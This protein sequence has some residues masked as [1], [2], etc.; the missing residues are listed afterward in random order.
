MEAKSQSIVELVFDERLK[1]FLKKAKLNL[2]MLLIDLQNADLF[3]AMDIQNEIRKYFIKHG[4]EL[5]YVNPKFRLSTHAPSQPVLFA[6]FIHLIADMDLCDEINHAMLQ[7]NENSITVGCKNITFT[8]NNIFVN[9][10]CSHSVKLHNVYVITNTMTNMKCY[11]GCSCIFKSEL[12]TKDTLKRINSELKNTQYYKD[13]IFRKKYPNNNCDIC[14]IYHLN[15]D[16]NR[17]D[18]CRHTHCGLNSCKNV[19]LRQYKIC[20]PCNSIIKK[21]GTCECCS[22]AID[23]R[24]TICYNCR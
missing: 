1:T 17:C 24:Y 9:C 13:M 8:D 20:F 4:S 11:A 21:T 2:K 16:A 5:T 22:K 23:S 6:L 12:I 10:A 14:Q 18:E 3:T 19:K 7:I 15:I